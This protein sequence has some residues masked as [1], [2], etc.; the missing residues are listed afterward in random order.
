MAKPNPETNFVNEAIFF[1]NGQI[2]NSEFAEIKG[3]SKQ[4]IAD[5][6][7]SY[8]CYEMVTDL[9]VTKEEWLD[10]VQ[11]YEEEFKTDLFPL[12]RC[13]AVAKL[14]TILQNDYG[15]DVKGCKDFFVYFFIWVKNK[16]TEEVNYI[17]SGIRVKHSL[18]KETKGWFYDGDKINHKIIKFFIHLVAMESINKLKGGEK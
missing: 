18:L 1:F 9:K 7:R 3:Y 11:G 4:N 8:I 15:N 13:F 17:I 14:H 2:N 5:Y 10:T 6:V 16:Q 12:R